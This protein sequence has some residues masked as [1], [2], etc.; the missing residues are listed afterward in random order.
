[1]CDLKPGEELKVT[2]PNGKRFVLPADPAVHDYLFFAT[3]T[4]IAPFRGMLL[5]LF[6]RRVSSRIVLVM[7]SPYASDL[8][9]HKD[10][11]AWQEEHENF[12][13]LTAISRERQADG[14]AMYAHERMK[15]SRDAVIPVLESPRGLVYI[16]GIA[17]M[18]LGVFQRMTT[19]L[20]PA[21][22]SSTFMW[23]LRWCRMWQ[24]GRAG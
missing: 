9:Y 14:P 12:T 3:G 23:T 24:D 22:R 17:G 6:R 13:Y 4:G 21:V 2:G 1:L 5:D 18:E 15:H 8:L 7:G 10:L 20:S 11:L 19:E 16:C